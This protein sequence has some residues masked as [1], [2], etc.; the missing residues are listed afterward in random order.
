MWIRTARGFPL[1]LVAAAVLLAALVAWAGKAAISAEHWAAVV[2]SLHGRVIAIDPGHGGIDPGAIGI[3]GLN[4]DVVNLAV[5]QQLAA[6]LEQAGAYAV[7]TR[8][9]PSDLAGTTSGGPSARKR[10]DLRNRVATVNLAGADVVISIHSNL[11]GNPSERGA[12]TFYNPDRFPQNRLLAQMI[13]KQVQAIT[14]ETKRKIS[15]QL[16][17]YL[18]EHTDMPGVTVELGFLSN[19]RDAKLLGDSAYQHKIAY[20]IFVGLAHYFAAVDNPQRTAS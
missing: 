5:S 6:L 16:D 11:Y 18:L 13:Q 8:D 17:H 7:L 9:G 1:V 10:V 14:G 20:A 2:S 3:G 12:Q 19:P 4:E 15:G